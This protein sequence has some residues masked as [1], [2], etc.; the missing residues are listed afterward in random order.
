MKKSRAHTKERLEMTKRL[1]GGSALTQ[2]ILV[3]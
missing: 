1:K 3:V 2:H